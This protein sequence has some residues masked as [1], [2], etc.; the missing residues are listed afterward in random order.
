MQSA[1]FD[2][3]ALLEVLERHE[4]D[5]VLIGG[6]AAAAH[7]SARN[8]YDLDIAYAREAD[9]L[10]R[11]AAALRELG[12]TLRGARPGLRFTADAET[13]ERGLNF[14]FSTRFGPLDVLGEPAGAPSYRELRRQADVFELRGSPLRV[15]SLDH[16]IAM[17]EAAGRSHDKAT[18]VELR[19]VSDRLRA[20]KDP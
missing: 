1:E 20:P 19:A 18:A 2:P 9:N 4:V 15:A 13:L 12:A 8:T 6:L 14:T 17:K 5:F 10:R 3:A 16:L 7:G 11:L